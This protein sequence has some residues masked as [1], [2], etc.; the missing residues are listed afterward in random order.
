MSEAIPLR[1]IC[2]GRWR[3]LLPTFGVADTFLTGRHGPCPL[4]GGKD[5]FRFDDKD[6]R[7]TWICSQCGAGDG[8]ALAMRAG[9]LDFK[10]FA[11]KV[12]PVV[13][14]VKQ[15]VTRRQRSDDKLRDAMN[16]VWRGG[17]GIQSG[18]FVDAY[19]RARGI[20]LAEFPQALRAHDRVRYQDQNAPADT[21]PRWLPAMLAKVTAPD[22]KPANVHRT[23]LTRDGRKADV[24]SPR[25][26]MAGRIPPGSA[27]RLAPS[28]DRMGIAEGLETAI[29]ASIIWNLPCWAAVNKNML[30]AWE[31]PPEATE[32]VVFVDNDKNYAGQSAGYA[33]G[34]RL[35]AKG[36]RCSVE[37]PPDP[38]TDWNDVL[39]AERGASA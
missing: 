36:K 17:V 15:S 33:L 7:G 26:I 5:R 14:T 18:D 23:Y 39:Q 24:E 3:G 2:R 35:A 8:I 38:D 32:I 22:G 29:S 25:K 27:V 19:L 10:T 6:G 13:G 37:M 34:H 4:C 11:E 12:E 30:A 31:P 28:A 21:S 9:G 20:E 1:D 16:A